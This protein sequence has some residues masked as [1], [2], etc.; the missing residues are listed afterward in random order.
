MVE[1]ENAA[2]DP[3]SVP[4]PPQAYSGGCHCGKVRYDVTADLAQVYACNCSMCQKK[5]TL[6]AFVPLDQF[7]LI[8]GGDLLTDYQFNKHMIHHLF[9][10]ICGVTSFARGKSEQGEMAAI[11]VRCLDDIDI[12]A[13]NVV[14]VDGRSI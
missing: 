10:T 8:K 6:L 9:C 4:P 5:G 2:A 7:H 3:V 13:L 12:D 1:N 11:N 14:K